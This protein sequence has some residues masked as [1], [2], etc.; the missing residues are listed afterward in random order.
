MNLVE[1]WCLY[2]HFTDRGS[3][4]IPLYLVWKRANIKELN[5]SGTLNSKQQLIEHHYR[6]RK[7]EFQSQG[8][9]R[10]SMKL[11]NPDS[12]WPWHSWTHSSYESLYNNGIGNTSSWM[13]KGAH[14][15]PSLSGNLMNVDVREGVSFASVV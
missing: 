11:C 8:V 4:W 5:S 10:S 13:E 6:E 15:A 9:G 14:K 7:K 1:Q 3:Y 12:S 2:L